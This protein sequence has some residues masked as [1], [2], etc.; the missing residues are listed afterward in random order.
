MAIGKMKAQQKEEDR[1]RAR[2]VTNATLQ[3]MRVGA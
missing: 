1:E 2:K 3:R